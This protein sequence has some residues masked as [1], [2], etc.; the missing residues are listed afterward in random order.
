MGSGPLHDLKMEPVSA[1]PCCVLEMTLKC[2]RSQAAS[3]RGNSEE[4][5]RCGSSATV[6]LPAED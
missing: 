4:W 2:G 3:L 5:D 6:C 1:F